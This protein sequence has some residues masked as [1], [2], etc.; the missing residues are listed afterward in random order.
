M[1]AMF[2]ILPPI[3][4][5][6]A[7]H[8]IVVHL[9]IG[10]LMTVPVLL[11]LSLV[12]PRHV[13]GLSIGALAMLLVGTVGAW[14]AVATGLAAA[15]L[16]DQSS[17]EQLSAVLGRHQELAERTR[18]AFTVL[19]AIYI[20][21]VALPALARRPLPRWLTPALGVA[22]LVLYMGGVLLL[23]NTGHLGGRLVHEF[24][25]HAIIAKEKP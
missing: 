19:S 24:G 15:Q 9:P 10:V 20:A 18:S 14:F 5:W 6:D 3:P 21:I 23:A 22:F 8:V 4:D 1:L 17:S 12:L 16:V 13:R 25:Q 11:V 7:A 2:G